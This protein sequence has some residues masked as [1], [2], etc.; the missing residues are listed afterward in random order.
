MIEICY[1]LQELDDATEFSIRPN[2]NMWIF[3]LSVMHYKC[4]QQYGRGQKICIGW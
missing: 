3:L 2:W 4:L 1:F